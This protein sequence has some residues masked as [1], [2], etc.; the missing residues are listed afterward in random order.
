MTLS[1]VVLLLIVVGLLVWKFDLKPF[2]A[3]IVLMLGLFLNG[4]SFGNFCEELITSLAKMASKIN[5]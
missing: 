4:T 1:V 2:H 3:I 5:F